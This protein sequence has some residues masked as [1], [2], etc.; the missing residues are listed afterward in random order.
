MK[1]SSGGWSHKR[2]QS[3]QVQAVIRLRLC[4]HIFSRAGAHLLFCILRASHQRQTVVRPFWR[5]LRTFKIVFFAAFLHSML[6]G[7]IEVI[8]F[9]M[10]KLPSHVNHLRRS[11]LKEI[12]L[13][14]L[15]ASYGKALRQVS[16]H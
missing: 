9:F 12:Y 13:H 11:L 2:K 10:A 5:N 16:A 1:K 15:M 6:E 7:K 4:K 3:G 8:N 14:A